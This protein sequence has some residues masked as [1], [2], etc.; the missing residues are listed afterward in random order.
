MS[1][2]LPLTLDVEEV[3][4]KRVTATNE[5]EI[6]LVR[7]HDDDIIMYEHQP[8]NIYDQLVEAGEIDLS[9]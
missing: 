8:D 4:I 3:K 6:T 1:E 9:A 5:W 2:H 7:E